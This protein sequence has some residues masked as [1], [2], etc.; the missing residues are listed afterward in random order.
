MMTVSMS[1]AA[2]LTVQ[3]GLDIGDDTGRTPLQEFMVEAWLKGALRH[4]PCHH[5]LLPWTS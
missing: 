5:Y 4:K 3:P 1:A 2:H